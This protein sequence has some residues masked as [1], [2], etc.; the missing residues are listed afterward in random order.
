MGSATDTLNFW[1]TNRIPRVP[2]TR[3]M[4]WFSRIEHPW[5]A[6]VSIKLWKLAARDLDLTE[7][8]KTSFNSLHDCFIRELKPGARP[9]DQDPSTVTS[10]CDGIV[11]AAG[12]IR[13]A[14]MFQAKGMSYTLEALLAGTLAAKDYRNGCYVALRL[15]PTMYHRFHAPFDCGVRHVNY[16][17][18]DVWNVNPET[19][20]RVD[21]LYC[22][23]ERAILPLDVQGLGEC[24]VLVPVAA[25]LVASIRLHFLPGPLDLGYPGPGHIDCDATFVKGDEMGYF[26]HGSTILVL[27][28]R[29]VSPLG[30]IQRGLRI[31]MGEG[32]MALRVQP[33]SRGRADFTKTVPDCR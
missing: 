16:V 4:G 33:W 25:I 31:R 19:L 27:G 32:L 5:I 1:L 11:M 23:N 26:Q 17:S 18:G 22:R 30:H 13:G 10:P 2:I 14:T 12:G 8:K 28:T 15:T 7:A 6:R 24:I 9:V 20:A 3:L 29:D 21:R